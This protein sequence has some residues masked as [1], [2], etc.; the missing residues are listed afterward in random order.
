MMA[1]AFLGY[2]NSLIWFFPRN[3]NGLSF[4]PFFFVNKNI[5]PVKYYDN[6]HEVVTQKTIKEDSRRKAAIYIIINKS[7]GNCY[8]G[9]ASTNR[10]N[11]RFRNHCIHLTGSRIVRQA[12]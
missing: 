5:V 4:L 10:I 3:Y 9:S 8:I 7:N 6:L 1:I 12:I 11:T 2:K